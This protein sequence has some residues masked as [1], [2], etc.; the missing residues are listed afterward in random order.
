MNHPERVQDFL[1][2]IAQAIE[3]ATEYVQRLGDVSTHQT[4]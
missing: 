2:H 4:L 3:R 1:E